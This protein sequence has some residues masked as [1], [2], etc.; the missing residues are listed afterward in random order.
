MEDHETEQGEIHVRLLKKRNSHDPKPEN[1]RALTQDCHP[2]RTRKKHSAGAV[3]NPILRLGTPIYLP[4][5]RPCPVSWNRCSTWARDPKPFKDLASLTVSIRLY[6][7]CMG[8]CIDGPQYLS[9]E[10]GHLY[11]FVKVPY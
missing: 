9:F 1:I 6:K 8:L 10:K 4:R 11:V 5:L 3:T 7:C 2:D